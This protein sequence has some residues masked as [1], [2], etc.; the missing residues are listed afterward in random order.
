MGS[1]RFAPEEHSIHSELALHVFKYP[2]RRGK[3]VF[4]G[5][6]DPVIA[7]QPV[8]HTGD[9]RLAFRRD[10]T[11]YSIVEA[12]IAHHPCTTVEIQVHGVTVALVAVFSGTASQA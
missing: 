1:R 7:R 8:F 11:V 5:W 4:Y 10:R 2:P 3:R 9:D 6:A 12:G